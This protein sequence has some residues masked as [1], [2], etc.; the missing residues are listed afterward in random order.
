[1]S[2]EYLDTNEQV[3]QRKSKL[4]ALRQMGNPFPNDFRPRHQAAVLHKDYGL[5]TEAELLAEPLGVVAIAGRMMTRRLMGKASFIHVQ[6][7]T[8]QIQ[9][10]SES[11]V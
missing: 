4:A 8:G 11:V 2:T 10:R 7:S 5:Y 1:M 3:E 9:V 6:D